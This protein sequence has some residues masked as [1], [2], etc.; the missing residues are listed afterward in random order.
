MTDTFRTSLRPVRAENCAADV[1]LQRQLTS[2]EYQPTPKL[3][4][5]QKC[6]LYPN[7]PLVLFSQRADKVVRAG[8]NWGNQRKARAA[9]YFQQIAAEF[10]GFY[11]WLDEVND[12]NRAQ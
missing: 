10:T 8:V 1:P 9:A 5:E 6:E 4:W 3:T 11:Q 12:R 7:D 2:D